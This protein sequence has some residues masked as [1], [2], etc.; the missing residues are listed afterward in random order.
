[1][2]LYTLIFVFLLS[3]TY[4]SISS[5]FKCVSDINKQIMRVSVGFYTR[6]AYTQTYSS[7]KQKSVVIIIEM[8]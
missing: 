3:N 7:F 5:L 6:I 2:H 1:M 8:F 4:Y